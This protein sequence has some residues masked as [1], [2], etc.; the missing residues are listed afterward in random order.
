[1]FVVARKWF[2]E[3]NFRELKT[4]IP[5]N[6]ES[7]A[8]VLVWIVSYFGFNIRLLT[9]IDAIERCECIGLLQAMKQSTRMTT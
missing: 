5:L 7:I 3:S 2:S 4:N 8:L 6:E 1:M 9:Q